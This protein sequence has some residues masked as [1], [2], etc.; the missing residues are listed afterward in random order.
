LTEEVYVVKR[1]TLFGSC[2][3]NG[4]IHVNDQIFDPNIITKLSHGTFYPRPLAEKNAA[5][6]QIIPYTIMTYENKVFI[7]KRSS[8]QDEQRLHGKISLGVGG[9]INPQDADRLSEPRNDG[10]DKYHWFDKLYEVAAA[11]EIMEEVIVSC[12]VH[13][14]EL[15][16]YINDDTDDVGSVHFGVILRYDLNDDRLGIRELDKMSGAM[17]PWGEL[18]DQ[19]LRFD[20]NM[21]REKVENWS[22]LIISRLPEIMEG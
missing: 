10:S 19:W 2:T 21:A 16:G 20:V 1:E 7:M 8:Q 3:P 17:R 15:L 22:N 4:F 18:W 14:L 9:H 11:R 6:K 13:K 12:P 5:Y